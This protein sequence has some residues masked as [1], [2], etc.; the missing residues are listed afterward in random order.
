MRKLDR[1]FF[2]SRVGLSFHK[3]WVFPPRP[4]HFPALARREAAQALSSRQERRQAAAAAGEAAPP[5]KTGT[6]TSSVQDHVSRRPKA[7]SGGAGRSGPWRWKPICPHHHRLSR[8]FRSL[9]CAEPQA[10]A[11]CPSLHNALRRFQLSST[12]RKV[13][14]RLPLSGSFVLLIVSVSARRPRVIYPKSVPGDKS[15]PARTDPWLSARSYPA[16]PTP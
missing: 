15:C 6:P 2:Y 8:T 7:R 1:Q 11:T 3:I 9:L 10:F 12:A 5:G 14:L 4:L 16:L 13:S